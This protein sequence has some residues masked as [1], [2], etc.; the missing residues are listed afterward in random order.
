VRCPS[1]DR[2]LEVEDA[3]RDWTVRCPHCGTEFVPTEVGASDRRR[4]PPREEPDERTDRDRDDRER[5]YRRRERDR[6][7]EYE[8]DYERN[9]RRERARE[10]ALQIVAAPALALEIVGWL[11]ALA[12]GGICALCVVLALEMNNGNRNANAGDEGVLVVMGCCAGVL[13]I[14]YSVAMGIGARKMRDLSSR[15]WAMAAGILGIAAFSLFGFFGV[16]HA[17]IG[18]WALV[19][20]DNPVVRAAYGLPRRR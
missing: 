4:R 13:G 7:D 18:T 2:P 12:S 1:C 9:E 6:D 5:D 16:I 14:P 3:Y 20:L 10:R 17:G 11:G 15:G 19:T 8:D